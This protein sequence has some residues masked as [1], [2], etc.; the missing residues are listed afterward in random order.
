MSTFRFSHAQ[1]YAIWLR[2]GKQC[3]VCTEP[4]RLVEVSID[5]VIP[6][7][8]LSNDNE[9][10]HV[11]RAYGLDDSTF[12]INGYEN[13]LPAHY[14][15]NQVKSGSVFEFVPGIKLCLSRLSKLGPS[16]Q[17]TA[18][19]VQADARTQRALANVLDA[20]ASGSLSKEERDTLLAELRDV[21]TADTDMIESELLVR[22]NPSEQRLQMLAAEFA[23]LEEFKRSLY[24]ISLQLNESDEGDTSRR[25][26]EFLSG[27]INLAHVYSHYLSPVVRKAISA[28]SDAQMRVQNTRMTGK[29]PDGYEDQGL[30]VQVENEA[31][32]ATILAAS[33]KWR[34][35]EQEAERVYG[36]VALLC[37]ECQVAQE[38]AVR[39]VHE[40]V[41]NRLIAIR[42]ERNEII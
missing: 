16:V 39:L 21:G 19:R 7:R 23:S 34:V 18:E 42:A 26:G 15:C 20:V 33:N 35:S 3:Y 25:V 1:K 14:R 2:H 32:R 27:K 31:E 22:P 6:E 41:D 40:S 9:R 30:S 29:V 38:E 5:H 8:L 11:F 4:L 13:W 10:G 12:Q 17:K 36:V 37:Q 28:G 24:S